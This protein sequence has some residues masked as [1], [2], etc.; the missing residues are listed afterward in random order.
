MRLAPMISVGSGRTE[1]GFW[2][3]CWTPA[4][5]YRECSRQ[6]CWTNCRSLYMC[7]NAYTPTEEPRS[8][9]TKD[10]IR[11]PRPNIR[12]HGAWW[13]RYADS[14]LSFGASDDS[15]YDAGISLGSTL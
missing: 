2:M 12:T 6:P 7:R 1:I 9:T 4:L 5:L 11:S 3:D 8:A 13:D 15:V 10:C 14:R